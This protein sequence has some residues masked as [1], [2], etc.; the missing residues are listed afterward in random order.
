MT[1]FVK[2][3]LLAALAIVL[4]LWV[5]LQSHQPVMR[6]KL[7]L[8]GLK[9]E[10]EVFFDDYGVPHIYATNAQDAYRAFGYVHAQDRLFQM[11][12]M[13]RV[14]QGRL[15]EIFGGEMKETDAFFR[16][17]GT[18]RKAAEDA[19][20]FSE[21][22]ERVKLTTEAY[23]AGVNQF[24][25][26]GKIPLEYKILRIEPDTFD[27]E[28]LYAIS[29]YMAYSFAYALRTDPLVEDIARNLGP[30]Y[31]R[32]LDLAVTNDLL[33]PDTAAADTLLATRPIEGV[34]PTRPHLPD[35]LPLP[36]LQGS[37]NWA[38]A[39][40]RTLSGKVMLANDT[41]IRYAAPCAW[42]EAHI[43]YPG[44]GFYGN[45]LAG[46]PVAL[47]GH[48]RNHA[49]GLTMF[50]DDDTDFFLERFVDDD[51]LR[52]LLRD[53]SEAEVLKYKEVIQIKG[54]EDTT[55]H[56]LV[57][58]HGP[59]INEFLPV[60]IDEPVSMHWNYMASSNRLLEALYRMNHAVDMGDFREG[61][62]AI[63]A[64]G[65][66][67]AYGDAAGNIALW[68]AARLIKRSDSTDGKRFI[69]GYAAH[70]EH[71]GYFEFQ[72]NP[73]REN[74]ASGMVWSA[75]QFHDSTAGV[76][77]PG[78]YAPDNRAD[79]LEHLLKEAFPATVESMKAVSLDVTSETE[80]EVASRLCVILRNSD[81][82]FSDIEEV[83]LS[84]L[85]EWD[86][87]HNLEDVGPTIYYKLLYY[88][89]R[90]TMMDELG[91]ERFEKLLETHLIKRSYPKLIALE[92]SPWWDDLKSED[93]REK[94]E[95]IVLK[96]FSKA[97][98]EIES[99]LGREPD[100]WQW[101]K[102]HFVEH[103]HPFSQV[104]VLNQFFHVGPFPAPGGN[105]TV[106][107]AGFTF[108]GDGKYM[109]KYGP[110]M[111]IIID[112]ADVEHALSVLPTGN[113]GNVMSPHYADQAEMYVKGEFREMKMN[114]KEIS[115]M[116]NRLL[117]L[118]K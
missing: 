32:S 7:D 102:V 39:P 53:S 76:A 75:N 105:E 78:Y 45:F 109:A 56:V 13:R 58:A 90:H 44:F 103:P 19:R 48:S 110:A 74:P 49:W 94:R 100:E 57:T 54:G 27:V 63:T 106:N 65:L 99:E 98:M 89:L 42:Y 2:Y 117:L 12:L 84:K 72:E 67:V 21:L 55:F 66:N 22:P 26:Q 51:S 91:E 34:A 113:S 111:R 114:R 33:P 115:A 43:E 23:L 37:N 112:F 8:E 70:A 96:S 116:G 95:R 71:R 38:L 62:E 16:T 118:P 87:S 107:N 36:T 29:A 52:T 68:S 77:Y 69:P 3:F 82:V 30:D 108:N 50:E 9:S 11:E 10:V 47:I 59:L 86:G 41:H 80:R 15:S 97:L 35:Q 17:L 40:S 60:D 6:G 25:R 18:H 24:I 46:I 92:S 83:A 14:G 104:S 73:Q 4:I 64:P 61:V 85:E 31:L 79:R 93:K 1:K 28:D 88:V 5:Y 81:A 20:R 101:K